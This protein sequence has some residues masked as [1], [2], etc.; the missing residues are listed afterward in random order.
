M[1]LRHLRIYTPLHSLIQQQVTIL[2]SLSVEKY[3]STNVT[4]TKERS[5]GISCGRITRDQK[6]HT[7]GPGI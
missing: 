4:Q 7:I 5:K 1:A 3:E 2:I 6:S